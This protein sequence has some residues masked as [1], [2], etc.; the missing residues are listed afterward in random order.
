MT[1]PPLIG[2]FHFVYYIFIYTSI[3]NHSA[4]K[5]FFYPFF[6]PLLSKVHICIN[7]FVEGGGKELMPI[8]SLQKGYTLHSLHSLHSLHFTFYDISQLQGGIYV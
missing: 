1:P 6:P 3:L 7:N 8:L 5:S 2:L 4:V